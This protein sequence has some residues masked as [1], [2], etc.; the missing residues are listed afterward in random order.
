[1]FSFIMNQH[2]V[3]RLLPFKFL[4]KNSTEQFVAFTLA[5]FTVVFIPYCQTSQIQKQQSYK[6]ADDYEM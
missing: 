6:N 3:I 5:R 4:E 2:T 1:M